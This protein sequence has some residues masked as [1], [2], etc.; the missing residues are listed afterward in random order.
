MVLHRTQ[1][2]KIT[3]Q[4]YHVQHRHQPGYAQEAQKRVQLAE[5][6]ARALQELQER[7]RRQEK[8][9]VENAVRRKGMLQGVHLVDMEFVV[10][11]GL[12]ASHPAF[13]TSRQI[14]VAADRDVPA[15]RV[16]DVI[17]LT[18]E[19]GVAGPSKGRVVERAGAR[20]NDEGTAMLAE[21]EA[22]APVDD[23]AVDDADSLYDEPTP[24]NDVADDETDSLFNEPTPVDRV[25][26]VEAYNPEAVALESDVPEGAVVDE[27]APVDRVIDVEAY[28][29]EAADEL[30]PLNS[31]IPEGA[32][33]DEDGCIRAPDPESFT[34]ERADLEWMLQEVEEKYSE[35]VPDW[36]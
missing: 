22:D 17:D 31:V 9:V 19:D 26:D 21:V 33:V 10:T 12:S 35:G 25:I 4:N 16:E 20:G 2:P 14:A 1:N 6:Q 5:Q 28:N 32:V 7:R 13:P 3:K 18:G 11:G 27:S 29:P 8:V 23:E 34:E 24:M 30:S 15:E 36:Y